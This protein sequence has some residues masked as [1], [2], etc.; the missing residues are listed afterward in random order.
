MSRPQ[1]SIAAL[2]LTIAAVAVDLAL[3]LRVP[4][5]TA[6]VSFSVIV[7]VSTALALTGLGGRPQL[8]AFCIGA[9]VPLSLLLYFVGIEGLFDIADWL[10]QLLSNAGRAA[11]ET[12]DAHRMGNPR[13]T[14]LFGVGILLSIALGYLCVGFRWLIAPR[15]DEP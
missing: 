6:F 2:L 1:F 9:L 8:R 4:T 11:D 13:F 12:G 3:M 10:E 7:I 14:K 15:K 5:R